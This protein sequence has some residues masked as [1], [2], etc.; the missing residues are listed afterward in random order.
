MHDPAVIHPPNLKNQWRKNVWR[1]REWLRGM[2]YP[3]TQ[4]HNQPGTGTVTMWLDRWAS[5]CGERNGKRILPA[6]QAA[7]SRQATCIEKIGAQQGREALCW[8]NSAGRSGGGKK[9]STP[10]T[11]FPSDTKSSHGMDQLVPSQRIAQNDSTWARDSPGRNFIENGTVDKKIRGFSHIG[12]IKD[13]MNRMSQWNSKLF[14]TGNYSIRRKQKN[15]NGT[16]QESISRPSEIRR[17]EKM[18]NHCSN[19]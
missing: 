13:S 10:L 15:W 3:P 4:P 6:A 5:P 17:W 2:H 14:C 12:S 1:S 7:E 16:V 18:K 9:I 8:I 19:R 11:F